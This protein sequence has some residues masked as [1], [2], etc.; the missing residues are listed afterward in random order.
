MIRRLSQH[1]LFRYIIAGGT[2]A[3]VDIALLYG[4]NTLLGVHYL[5]AAIAA[6]IGAFC[7]SFVLQK[8]WTFRDGSR[9]RMHAQIGLYLCTSLFGLALN[10]LLMYLFVD[11]A[12]IN[13]ILSQVFAGAIV[14]CCTFFLSRN[15]V[16][17]NK[18]VTDT[19]DDA[20]KDSLII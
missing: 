13:V 2:A 16:F 18:L 14:A 7:V 9:D 5:T 12:H 10:T 20:A 1:M 3:T 4:L 15:F 6:F 11:K 19:R 17:K 8:F